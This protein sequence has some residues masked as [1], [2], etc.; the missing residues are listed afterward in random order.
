MNRDVSIRACF[1]EHDMYYHGIALAVKILLSHA[2]K[3]HSW[4][5]TLGGAI[6]G[7]SA[8]EAGS[9]GLL[10]LDILPIAVALAE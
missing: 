2:H 5:A 1:A 8:A 7:R 6:C 3:W 4:P 9:E 10:A